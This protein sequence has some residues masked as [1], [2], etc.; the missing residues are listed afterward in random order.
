MR[1]KIH[2]GPRARFIDISF[3][4]N[5]S[6]SVTGEDNALVDV[7][8]LFQVARH[9]LMCLVRSWSGDTE[10]LF[11]NENVSKV[12]FSKDYHS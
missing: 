2:I 11:R 8:Y 10:D 12:E 4:E 3:E 1:F 9:L 6:N 7:K 5:V